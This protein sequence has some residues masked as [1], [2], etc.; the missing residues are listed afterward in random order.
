MLHIVQLTTVHIANDTRIFFKECLSLGNFGYKVTLVAGAPDVN[1]LGNVRHLMLPPIQG[2]LRRMVI[3]PWHALRL[4]LAAKPDICHFHDPELIP[5]A[6]FLKTF[7]RIKVIYDVHE[8]VPLQIMT[9]YWIRPGFRKI[10]SSVFRG[11]ENWAARR[12]DAIITATPVIAQRFSL[13]N[14]NTVSVANFPRAGRFNPNTAWDHRPRAVGYVGV[15][16]FERGIMELLSAVGVADAKLILA[17]QFAS[18]EV[19]KAA[20]SHPEWARVEYLGKISNDAVPAMLERVRAGIVCLHP[21][22]NYVESQP[23]KMFEYMAAGLPVVGSDFPLWRQFV[24]AAGAGLLV[25]PKDV[26]AIAR[27]IIFMLENEAAA[28][29]MG[30]AGRLAVDKQYSWEAQAEVLHAVYRKLVPSIA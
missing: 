2:R 3:R 26:P 6:L 25:D 22:S 7:T 19:E 1:K 27:A 18:E 4:V 10:V 15:I 17:G 23:V 9:K 14:S 16:T 20:R 28:R 5:L 24:T 8:D 11:V 29:E 30:M 12:F 13:Q 21:S